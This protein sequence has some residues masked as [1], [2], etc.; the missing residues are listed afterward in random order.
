MMRS[1]LVGLVGTLVIGTAASGARLQTVTL[2]TKSYIAKMA[3]DQAIADG[4]PDETTSR[5]LGFSD[6]VGGRV[7]AYELLLATDL[8]FSED[9]ASSTQDS[10]M[11]RIWSQVSVS[12]ACSQGKITQWQIATPSTAFGTDL[13]LPATGALLKPL[14]ASPGVSGTTSQAKV[15]FSYGVKGRPNGLTTPAFENIRPRTCTWIWH[16]VDAEATCN[17]D[18]LAVKGTLSGSAFPSHKL[19]QD[20]QMTSIISQGPFDSLWVCKTGD[21]QLIR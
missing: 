21:T 4:R 16:Q 7:Q 5:N 20:G 14:S 15:T 18:T 3:T 9:P 13:G 8:M 6:L 12:G 17:G 10:G 11:F 2:E 19:W 1:I